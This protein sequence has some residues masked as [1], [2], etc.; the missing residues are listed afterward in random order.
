MKTSKKHVND[1]KISKDKDIEHVAHKTNMHKTKKHATKSK[2]FTKNKTVYAILAAIVVIALLIFI[3]I[4]PDGSGNQSY[5][6]DKVKV[7]FYVMSQCPYGTQVENIIYPLFET[8]GDAIDFKLDYIVSE[9]SQGN[10]QSLHG[11]PEV[12]GDIAQLCAIKYY[13]DDYKYMDFIICQ[14]K[15]AKN[16]NT[17]WESCAKS[18]DMD[19]NKLKA[20]IEGAEGKALLRDSMLR[21]QARN[22]RGSPT[23]F[24]GNESYNGQRDAA[25]FQRAICKFTDNEACSNIPACSVDKDCTAEKGK[26]GICNNPGTKNA[27]CE[28][29]DAVEVAL[30]VLTSESCGTACDT[31]QI[32]SVSKQL[33]IGV[34][35]ETVD[36]DTAEGKALAEEYD[37]EKV[38]AY[39]FDEKVTETRSWKTTEGLNTAFQ[40]TKK[41]YRLKDEVTKASYFISEELRQAYY[42][43]IGVTFGDNRPQ[44]D[45]FV[46]SYC[47]YGNQAEEGIAPVYELLKD[48]ADFNPKY[49][50]YSNYQG[51][52]PN[53]CID[54]ASQLCSMHGV[55]EINQD[56]RE[57]CVNKY[58]GIDKWFEF[59]LAMNKKCTY[60]N[61]DTCW[62][63]VA[64]DL[65]LDIEKIKTCEA[66]EG[67]ILMTA[68]KEMGDALSVRGSPSVFIDGKTYS[69]GRTP[70]DYK[71]ALCAAFDEAPEEC[72][73][74]LEGG[75]QASDTQGQC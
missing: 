25:S 52:G 16:V 63:V 66:E 29:Q 38:P 53:Y 3:I 49:V 11:E 19:A 42:E 28:Y 70:E 27:S 46:M 36:V 57:A 1:K 14:N 31:S 33:F 5:S 21:S 45:F 72:S 2:S 71:K 58:M 68:D 39:L 18:N 69:G 8:M 24:I 60:K 4:K 50:I 43:T 26:I 48:K 10:F 44:I 22:A 64:A 73:T 23:I 61:A 54:E 65:S 30:T 12:I 13:P 6:G 75:T 59:A 17:N 67:E 9:P 7:E 55:Q 40:K 74:S 62:E 15:N 32:L 35:V 34:K 47:P 20:C 37:I 51:G 41:G 56:V